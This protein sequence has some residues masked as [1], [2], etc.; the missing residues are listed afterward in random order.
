MRNDSCVDF[1]QRQFPAHLTYIHIHPVDTLIPKNTGLHSIKLKDEQNK[2]IHSLEMVDIPSIAERP[3]GADSANCVC[4]SW[5]LI[6]SM[7]VCNYSNRN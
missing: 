5:S 2:E 6:R 4:A 3:K 7:S 1:C